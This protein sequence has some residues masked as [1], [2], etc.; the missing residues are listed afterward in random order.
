[1]IRFIFRSFVAILAILIG[2]GYVLPDDVRVE[3]E[4]VVAAPAETVFALVGDLNEWPKWS[5]WFEKDPDVAIF[6]DGSGVGQTQTWASDDPSVGGGTQTVTAVEPPNR[7]AFS[8][9]FDGRGQGLA[10]LVLDERDG[11]TT[12]R[13]SFET[14]MRDG[15]P[16]MQR[17]L[18]TYFGFF[19]DGFLGPD[20]ER[21]LANLKRLA[22]AP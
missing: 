20:F 13:W 5:P 4:I 2:L 21:G 22:E 9:A 17:P 10:A 14:R 1:M 6:V 12:L 3:R 18:A 7:V 19:M 16:I 11:R 15:A 8:L